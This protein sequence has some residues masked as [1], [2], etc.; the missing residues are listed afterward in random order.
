VLTVILFH[1]DLPIPGGCRVQAAAI[2][3]LADQ[4]R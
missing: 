1:A 4:M 3:L 2:P